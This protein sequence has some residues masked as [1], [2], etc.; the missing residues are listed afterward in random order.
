MMSR[1]HSGCRTMFLLRVVILSMVPSLAGAEGTRYFSVEGFSGFLDGNPETTA[2]TERG[3]VILAPVVFE[4]FVQPETSFSAAVA[5]RNDIVVARVEDGA[6]VSIDK[7]GKEK[8]L[9][10][11]EESLVTALLS[12][13][14]TLYI[15]TG[16][17]AKIYKFGGSGK[18]EL[19]YEGDAEHIWGMAAGPKG[20]IFCVTG[21][22][23]MVVKLDSKG[24]ET[25]LFRPEEQSLRSVAFNRKD[26]LVVGGGERGIVYRAPSSDLKGFH[27]I[28]DSTHEEISSILIHKGLVYA[29]AVS[30]AQA[31]VVEGGSSRGGGRDSSGV[32][33]Q[34]IRISFDGV[35]E[36]LAGSN[37]EAIFSMLVDGKG[38]VALS[39]GATGRKDPRGR[40]YSINPEDRSISL[41]YQSPSRRITHLVSLPGGA[42]AAV[43]SAGGRITQITGKFASEGKFLSAPVDVE[44]NATFGALEILGEFPKGSGASIA[45]RTGQT[46]TPDN[47]WSSWSKEVPYGELRAPAVTNG[48]YAQL[49]ATLKGEG[50]TTPEITRLKVAYLRKNLPPYVHEITSM[51]KGIALTPL[52][53]SGPKAR[54]I[55]IGSEGSAHRSEDSRKNQVRLKAREMARRGA[56]TIRWS[57]EDPNEDKLRYRLEVR[58]IGKGQWHSLDDGLEYPF[59]TLDSSQLPDGYYRFRVTATD[60]NSNSVGR[61]LTNRR[62]SFSILVD[63]NPPEV[64]KLKVSTSGDSLTLSLSSSDGVGPLSLAEFSLDG[65]EFR[66]ILPDDGVLDGRGEKFTIALGELRAGE[67]LVTVRVRDS[68]GNERVG[69]KNISVR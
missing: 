62:E 56:L 18:A 38:E 32:S 2:L 9:F 39:T 30:G 26:G 29:S 48:R 46:S 37:D 20:S 47:T 51:K 8:E 67:H 45:I 41:M 27:A 17:T 22:P 35:A 52:A 53:S 1:V 23:A 42:I 25:V 61:E 28:Y 11:A 43:A 14:K 68:A 58:P 33:S 49:R 12:V 5:Y 60:S 4:R 40:V 55:D 36:V 31:L 34:V 3:G 21:Q 54:T 44:I 66:Q 6:V 15:S 19:F 24:N 59:Y 69:E 7:K 64:S 50:K 16:P 57:A 13:K 10:K 63:N 65:A